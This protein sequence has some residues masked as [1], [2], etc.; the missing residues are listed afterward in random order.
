MRVR[1]QLS[2]LFMQSAGRIMDTDD[3]FVWA[4]I[5]VFIQAVLA[6]QR[7]LHFEAA[8]VEAEVDRLRGTTRTLPSVST[9]RPRFD[10]DALN[11][12]QLQQAAKHARYAR[13]HLDAVILSPCAFHNR[14]LRRAWTPE[15]CEK[16]YREEGLREQGLETEMS[17]P[18]PC[19]GTA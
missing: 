1:P 3:E 17:K 7:L 6:A 11:P 18:D 10:F 4:H 9:L 5:N 16:R 14:M 2:D 15:M 13:K 8:R 12:D 19:D